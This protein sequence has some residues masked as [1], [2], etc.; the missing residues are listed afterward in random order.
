MNFAGPNRRGG[1]PK[2]WHLTP[3]RREHILRFYDSCNAIPIAA[4]L[5]VPA[6]RVRR[7]AGELGVARTKEKPWSREDLFY[8]EENIYRKSWKALA[9]QL[10]RT[11]TAVK[12]KAKRL[13]LGKLTYRAGLTQRQL[14]RVLGVDDHCVSRWVAL[15]WLERQRRGTD[16]KSSQGG[17]SCLYSDEA[18]IRFVVDHFELVDLRRVDRDWLYGLIAG[19]L[20]ASVRREA[21]E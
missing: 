19:R 11:P 5:G 7:W 6:W 8:L 2:R 3:E 9:R 18:V 10:G 4:K 17:D 12:L 1:C 21:D 14:A 20:M 13:G 16:R 15:G